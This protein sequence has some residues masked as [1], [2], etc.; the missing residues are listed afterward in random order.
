MSARKRAHAHWHQR[1]HRRFK[2]SLRWRLVALFMLLALGTVI[3]F[4]GGTRAAL[5]GGFEMLVKPLLSDYVDRLTAEL[6]SPPEVVRAQAL[7]ARLPISVRIDNADLHWSSHPAKDERWQSRRGDGDMSRLFT[8]TTADGSRVQ[9]GLGDMVWHEPQAW[10]GLVPLL[11]LL[12]LTLAAYATVRRIFRPLDDI[13]SGALRYGEGDFSQAIPVRRRDELGDLAHQVNAMATGLQGMLQGQR[14]LLLAISHELRS[15]LTR[16][17]LNAELSADSAERQ[18]L[19]RDLSLMSELI[20]DLLESER[21]AAGAAALTREA[22]DLN[23]LVREVVAT[24]FAGQ[25]ITLA[26]ADELPPL[27]LDRPRATMLVRN[28]VDNACRHG[29]GEAV[30]IS[31]AADA[32]G[33]QLSVRDHGPGVPA[34]QLARLAEP[35]YRPDV[36]RTRAAGGVGLGLYLCK[37]VAQSHGGTLTLR[38]ASPGL[39]AEVRWPAM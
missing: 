19:L 17:R 14:A 8:R 25:P 4:I 7:V 21:L 35:F 37:L 10:R 15:P 13:R 26:L 18:A 1:W 22:T 39:A 6:G 9:F 5:S 31:T 27:Q 30:F 23:T 2:H 29:A 38:N 12:L 36:A 3:V 24:G 16:A 33:V 28:L 20:T 34:D 32:D 11:G